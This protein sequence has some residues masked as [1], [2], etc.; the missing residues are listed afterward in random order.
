MQLSSLNSIACTVVKRKEKLKQGGN[1]CCLCYNFKHC[2]LERIIYGFY[3]V[4]V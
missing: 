2:K 3:E 4:S 1:G